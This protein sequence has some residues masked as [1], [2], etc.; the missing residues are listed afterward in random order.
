[1]P[2]ERRS[3]I[4]R[5]LT[6][7]ILTTSLLGLS[8]ACLCSEIYERGSFRGAITS[9]LTALAG[10]LGANATASLAFS[11]KQSAVDI[12]KA[13]SAEPH[14]V[15]GCLYDKKGEFFAAYQRTGVTDRCSETLVHGEEARF[16]P[17]SVTVY[18]PISLG[19]EQVGW[20]VIT[21]DL[22]ALQAKI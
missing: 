16:E 14:V 12:L 17:D 19:S 4:Q 11:D 2:R 1:M 15:T 10:T 8:L 9:Q 3:S 22:G 20:I 21:S 7:V 6:F 5:K 13:L 18:R